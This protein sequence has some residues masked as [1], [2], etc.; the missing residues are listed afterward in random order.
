MRQ[1]IIENNIVISIEDIMSPSI[2]PFNDNIISVE[3]DN[4][5]IEIGWSYIDG[6]FHP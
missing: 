3:S 6:E 1:I 5:D 2:D 4:P